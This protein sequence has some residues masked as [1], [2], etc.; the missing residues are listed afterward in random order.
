MAFLGKVWDPASGTW[1]SPTVAAS[2]QAPYNPTPWSAPN[3]IAPTK[4]AAQPSLP[5]LPGVSAPPANYGAPPFT[6]TNSTK[7]LRVLWED[8]Q[9]AVIYGGDFP[10]GTGMGRS[11]TRTSLPDVLN[12]QIDPLLNAPVG[13]KSRADFVKVFLADLL[14]R[15]V[16]SPPVAVAQPRL[17]SSPDQLRATP[18][19]IAASGTYKGSVIPDFPHTCMRCGGK[20]YQGMFNAVHNTADGRCPAESKKK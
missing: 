14:A 12:A 19:R 20:Y 4:P 6:T 13:P 8:G 3:I 5:S 17:L 1:V 2:G 18:P 9:V 15:P 16:G 7:D 11:K 10:A